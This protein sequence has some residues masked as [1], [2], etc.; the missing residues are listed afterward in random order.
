MQN[1]I[2]ASKKVYIVFGVIFGIMPIV[3]TFFAYINSNIKRDLPIIVL[4][5]T[6][7]LLAYFLLSRYR[8]T[9]DN[10]QITYR[11]LF[12][13]KSIKIDDIKDYKIKTQITTFTKSIFGFNITLNDPLKP[14]V[15]LHI[16]TVRKRSELIIPANIFPADGLNKLFNVIEKNGTNLL[17]KKRKKAGKTVLS[18]IN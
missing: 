9:Y 4:T 7:W 8:I 16:D 3:I 18:Y 13:I 14:M 11:G 5:F 6:I 12:G 15:G 17:A 2:K 1:V 10:K